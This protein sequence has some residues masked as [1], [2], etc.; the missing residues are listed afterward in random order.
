MDSGD[1]RVVEAGEDLRLALEP[2]EAVRIPREGVRENL[3]CDLAVELRV[4]GLLDLSHA[5]LANEG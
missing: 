4:G 1:A 3:Q 5:P 2:G